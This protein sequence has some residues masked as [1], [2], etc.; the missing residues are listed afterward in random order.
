MLSECPGLPQALPRDGDVVVV[1]EGA[2]DQLVKLAVAELLPPVVELGRA[3]V[4]ATKMLAVAELGWTLVIRTYRVTCRDAQHGSCA[5][6]LK[7]FHGSDRMRG[8]GRS[9]FKKQAEYT[10]DILTVIAES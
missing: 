10:D 8:F 1:V 9:V 7:F 4:A 5:D 2:G 6:P 3:V